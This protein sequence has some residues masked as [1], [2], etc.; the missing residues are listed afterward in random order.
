MRVRRFK[1]ALVTGAS[2]GIGEAMARDLTQ[3]GANVVLVARSRDRLD[4]LAEEL[5]ATSQVE[6]EVLPADL[7]SE[8]GLTAVET[9]LRRADVPVDLLVNN[10]GMGQVGS[11]AELDVDA[12]ER[13]VRLNSLAPLRLSH[14]VLPRL[15]QQGGGLLNVSS[16]AGAQ[17]M[18][19]MATYGATK[20]FL[21]SLTQALREELRH[22]GVHVTLL[23]PGFVR[24]PFVSAAQ[25]DH[26]ATRIPGPLWEDALT[27]ARAGLDGVARDRAVVVP[28]AVNRAGLALSD[29]A[30]S[31]LSRRVVAVTTRRL[32]RGR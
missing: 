6:V 30:P 11:F 19:G 16:M 32:G 2:S 23:A 26:E 22:N 13:L 12:A 10:A 3:R 4:G 27:V 8:E 9:R 24:T 18:A 29:V 5:R 1:R 28:G 20:A 14:A 17:P 31:A 15:C 7:T 25:A 21:S